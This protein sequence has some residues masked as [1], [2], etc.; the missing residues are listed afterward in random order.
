MSEAIYW[1][2]AVNIHPG[3]LAEFKEVSAALVKSTRNES[4]TL[5]YEWTLSEDEQICHIYER[6]VDS[7]AIGTHIENNGERV[8]RLF[9]ISTPIHF[10]IYGSPDPKIRAQLADL[11]P[12]YMVPLDGFTR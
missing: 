6:Y 4:G 12:I 5:A 1:I 2:L 7:G 11:K 3:K 10:V 9:A 8:G